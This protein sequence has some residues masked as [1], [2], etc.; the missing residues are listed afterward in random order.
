MNYQVYLRETYA[1]WLGKLIGIRLGAPVEN[2]THQAIKDKYGS[3]TDYLVDYD[4]F[5]ADDDS[6]G[7]LFFIRVLL[8]YPL[9]Q[10]TAEAIG[11]TVLNYLQEYQGFFWWGGV[12]ISTEHTAYEN[13]KNGIKA[14]LSGRAATNGLALA[15]QIGGQIFSDCW[16]Y[17]SGYNPELAKDLAIKASSVTHDGNGIQGGIF[18][19]VAICLAYQIDDAK[20]IV[21]QTLSYLDPAMEYYQVAADIL[22]FHTAY[23]DDWQACLHYI[24]QNYGYDRYPGVCHI[25]PNAAVMIMALCYGANDFSRTL[26]ML[27]ECGW[28]TDCNCGNVGSIMGAMVGLNGIAEQWILPLN[29]TVNC[30]SMI[31][32][33]NNTTVSYTARLFT[34]LAFSLQQQAD[35]PLM[36]AYDFR[37]PYATNGFR[38][39]NLKMFNQ[40]GQLVLN[41]ELDKDCFIY[42]YAYYLPGDIYDTRYEPSFSP[43]L[44]PGETICFQVEA[45]AAVPLA[46]YVRDT[47]G[48]IYHQRHKMVL[49]SETLRYQIPETIPSVIHEFGIW[50]KEISE[51]LTWSVS[52]VD[53][54][55]EPVFRIDFRDLPLDDYGKTFSQNELINLR[56]WNI[57][58][59]QWTSNR[60]GLTGKCTDHGLI[61]CGDP[62]FQDY[63]MEAELKINAGFSSYIVFNCQGY[64][65]F[66]A[67]GFT[68]GGIT[69][70]EKNISQKV[71]KFIPLPWN[72][73]TK[74]ILKIGM[75]NGIMK[76]MINEMDMSFESPFIYN[77]KGLFGFYLEAGSSCTIIRFELGK[78]I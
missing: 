43:L 51:K 26:T 69:F 58:S 5:A 17:V 38:G 3:I 40:N 8:D 21:Q 27:C 1:A 11:N 30:S 44:Y 39:R 23:P 42:K 54:I 41:P 33:L 75:K 7:P 24:Q 20:M 31:G 50:Q 14:P 64:L 47:E 66:N 46:I 74:Y 65:H 72:F 61:T 68:Q 4:V 2:W 56:G 19:A 34:N 16:G 77:S 25:I 62:D 10:V 45:S 35:L 22:R 63:T 73:H 37:L 49:E 13:L 70:F 53:I 55:K 32:Y 76:T 71:V 67:I 29:D 6:N 52:A 18:V 9:E 59:G 36:P 60:F 28:D 57:H 78:P 48:N 12:G 15:E